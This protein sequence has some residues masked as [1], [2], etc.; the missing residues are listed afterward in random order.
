VWCVGWA[1]EWLN[2]IVQIREQSPVSK[3]FLF[4]EDF[5]QHS[6]SETFFSRLCEAVPLSSY[7]D[8]VF[9]N[10]AASLSI[11][12]LQDM[13]AEQIVSSIALNITSVHL[14]CRGFLLITDSL[15]VRLGRLSCLD[16]KPDVCLT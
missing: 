3:V 4:E 5:S 16:R 15:R 12:R 11:G 14:L 7:R 2:Y 10:N 1:C 6:A 9:V 13:T 8:I